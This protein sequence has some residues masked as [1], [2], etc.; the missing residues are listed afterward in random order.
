MI[1]LNVAIPDDLS[2]F[3]AQAIAAGQVAGPNELV[4]MA[5]YAL[6][7]QVDLE[8][9]RDARLRDRIA[10]GLKEVR[11]GKFADYDQEE[12]LAGMNA[13]SGNEAA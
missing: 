9:V 5:L 6:R 7:D 3:L 2:L 1:S 12:F 13:V 8:R 4:V 11:R 10:V